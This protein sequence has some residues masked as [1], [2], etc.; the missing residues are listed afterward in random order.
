MM[1]CCE[2]LEAKDGLKFSQVLPP[3]LGTTAIICPSTNRDSELAGYKMKE[4]SKRQ[5]IDA[6]DN[7]GKTE[8]AELDRKAQSVGRA[9][10]CRIMERSD[11]LRVYRRI[12]SSRLSGKA[13]KLSRSATERTERRG[14]MFLSQ[15]TNAVEK[16]LSPESDRD[17]LGQ[18]RRTLP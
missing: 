4:G 6:E 18:Q 9:T 1:A 13:S 5:L 7:T 12:S 10:A 14:V 3:G 8:I 11:S 17:L 16:L 2:R 15:T